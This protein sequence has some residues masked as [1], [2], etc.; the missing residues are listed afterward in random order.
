VLIAS[1]L[2]GRGFRLPARLRRG[3]REVPAF[4]ADVRSQVLAEAPSLE[5]WPES[6]SRARSVAD[7]MVRLGRRDQPLHLFAA[8][9]LDGATRGLA[10]RDGPDDRSAAGRTAGLAFRRPPARP[11]TASADR[12]DRLQ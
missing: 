6:V 2:V 12:R 8:P 1:A 4:V 9:G 10:G 5:P 3:A 7:A 11:R